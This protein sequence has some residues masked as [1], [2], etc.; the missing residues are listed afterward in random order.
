MTIV[1]VGRA[2][3]KKET[4]SLFRKSN[5]PVIEDAYS[6]LHPHLRHHILAMNNRKSEYAANKLNDA[7]W[8][9]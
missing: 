9:D 2:S 5:V 7:R 6:N 1:I 4:T 8:I 3:W